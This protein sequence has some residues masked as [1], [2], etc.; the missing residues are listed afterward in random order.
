M[1][2]KIPIILLLFTINT[3]TAQINMNDWRVHFSINNTIGISNSKN[4]VFMATT[5]GIVKCDN[6]DNSISNL[7]VTNGLTD[8]NI[9]AI[10]DNNDVVIV[11]YVNGN[12]DVIK[13]NTITN[14]PW[15]KRAQISG[16]KTINNF[17]FNDNSIYIS[18]NIGIVV[19]NIE[20]N[21][22]ED[23]Y[24]PYTNAEIND[25]TIFNDSIYVATDNGIY[26]AYKNNNYLTDVNQWYKKL[27]LPTS[28][29]TGVISEIETFDNK[30]FFVLDSDNFNEDS[31]FYLSNTN[32]LFNYFTEPVSVVNLSAETDVLLV[33]RF[34]SVYVINKDLSF[35]D[36]IYDY[37][38]GIAP[39]PKG[40]ILF[41]DE[42]WIADKNNGMIRATSTWN[43]SQIF[44]NTPYSDGCYRLDIQY[45]SVLV[46][47]GGL[48]SN[49]HNNYF[50]NGAYLF[51]DETWVNFNAS[52]QA[53]I[54]DSLLWD[55]I[56]VSI[57]PNN[58]EQMAFGSYSKG[59]L[60]IINKDNIV[61][62]VYTSNNSPLETQS[63]NGDTHII[64]DV[65][66]DNDGNLWVVN[67]GVEPLKML[68]KDGIWYTFSLGSAAKDK[69]PYRL[70]IDS[71]GYKWVAIQ[72]VGIVVYNDNGTYSDT[73]DDEFVTL[74]TADGYG[75]L[76][77]N[78]VKSIAEDIDGE[79]WIGTETGLVV[80]YSTNTIF[81][82][83]YGDADASEILFK[84]GEEV[85]ILLGTSTIT[86]IVIDG[87]NRKWIGTSSSGVFCFSAN[88][89]EEI[90]RF[91][92]DN[93]PLLSNGI[94]DIKI[95][96]AS[97]EVYFATES[98]LIS[99]RA[100]ATIADNDFTNISVFPNPVRPDFGGVITIEGLGYESD[101][102]ITD[103]SG[104]LIYQTTSNGGTVIWDGKR[105]TGER[106]QSGVYLVWSASTSGK[107]KAV[108][109]ILFI[110]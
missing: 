27:D 13:D 51:K 33:S 34:S 89:T 54:K 102:K 12:L 75:S 104:N 4:V 96:H 63:G 20:K 74:T 92:T 53:E 17:Y 105:L 16:S 21:E 80:M 59:G 49:L 22:I 11:G 42:Y 38:F 56:C 78:A 28:I 61:D 91:N 30:L 25:L 19:Y 18:T 71:K 45:G 41:N 55:V 98:G 100:D 90:Y 24:H 94:L 47:G 84:Y 97:G 79:I 15:I 39:N 1:K 10:G 23:T 77:S 68:S 95:D 73:S 108:A 58:T 72:G 101:V 76:P 6:D 7:T 93:S 8:L 67:A 43:N 82:G 109:K 99:F 57:N 52:T 31:L 62:K 106:V 48:T 14:V 69:Y 85:E 81:D 36:L 9:S 66:Y 107:G 26:V 5:N 83:A 37:T 32:T 103:V 29:K 2:F 60:S 88:G 3:L 65:K 86:S 44:S 70:F 46:A 64:S 40:S 50:R 110:N 35:K 87:G